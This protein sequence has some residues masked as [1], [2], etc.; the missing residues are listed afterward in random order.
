MK[1]PL[2]QRAIEIIKYILAGILTVGAVLD[3]FAN[4]ISLL[5]P[6]IA[7]IGTVSIFWDGC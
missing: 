6:L 2:Y 1:P 4:A 7:G 5:T 3:S